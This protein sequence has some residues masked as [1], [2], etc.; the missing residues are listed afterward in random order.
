[1]DKLV[2]DEA[3]MKRL[4]ERMKGQMNISWAKEALMLKRF[5]V[6]DGQS[7]LEIG[8]GP[9]FITD[10]LAE[11]YP[12]S[13]VTAVEIEPYFA[14]YARSHLIPKWGE[15]VHVVEDDVTEPRN[16]PSGQYDVAIARL[17]FQHLS[18]PEAAA[19]QLYRLLKPGGKL[20]V[21]DVDDAVWGI[22]DPLIPELGFILNQHA[23][24]QS[25][26]GGDRFIG[27]KLW[28]ILRGAGFVQLDL[29]MIASHSDELGLEAFVPQTDPEEMRTMVNS[30]FI[31]ERELESAQAAIRN[32][33]NLPDA[34]ALLLMLA[35]YGEKPHSR[36]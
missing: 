22:V 21:L 30:G 32:F 13:P 9:G 16:L 17:V 33:L 1:M 2:M 15:R 4:T 14:A 5:G 12:S 26:E 18:A 8:S 19:S 7:I 20:I 10:R 6:E 11:M 28:R 24:E 35:F 23:K 36:N 27:R 31:T 34:Y 3:K 25:A 29:Q